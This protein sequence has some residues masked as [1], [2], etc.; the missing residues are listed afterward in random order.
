MQQSVKKFCIITNA[1]KDNNFKIANSIKS[2]IDEKGGEA[3]VLPNVLDMSQGEAHYTNPEL[4]DED[5]QCAIVVGGDGT[6]IQAAI[7]LVEKDLL[8]L[9]MNNGTVGYLTEVDLCNAKESIERLLK[10]DYDVEER[11]MLESRIKNKSSLEERVFYSLNDVV[12]FKR[13]GNRLI[14]VKVY[15]NERYLDTYCAD[16][17]ILAT[18]T[19]ST[20][21]NLSSGGPIMDPHTHAT[22]I[23]PIC[24]HSLNKRS[25]V[26]DSDDG[27]RFEI[28][29]TKE[30][31]SDSVAV[32]SD[33]REVANIETDDVLDACVPKHETR[34]IKLTNEGFYERMRAKIQG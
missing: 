28:M 24:P 19:G 13:G 15:A 34:F 16:G 29:Q 23:T 11:I 17:V 5:T 3:I 6:I 25:I 8:F 9:T 7:D 26:L 2:I 21:Y 30:N 4:I 32:I 31:I 27:V 33:G 18:P 20:G 14:T 12:L 10:G 1:D 22:V